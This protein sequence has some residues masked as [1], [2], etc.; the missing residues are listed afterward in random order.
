MESFSSEAILVKFNINL[1]FS[2]ISYSLSLKMLIIH[3]AKKI[4]E[5]IPRTVSIKKKL[6]LNVFI[7]TS[8][9][10]PDEANTTM[11]NIKTIIA[12]TSFILSLNRPFIF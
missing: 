10:K 11:I 12:P 9:T 1:V 5:E 8:D 7:N 6:Q 2:F 3:K 4:K